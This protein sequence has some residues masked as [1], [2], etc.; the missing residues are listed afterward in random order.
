VILGQHGLINWANDDKECYE[1]TLSLI[2]KAANYIE[3]KYEAKGG[4]AKACGGPKY[5][6]LD[7]VRRR[8]VFAATT[9]PSK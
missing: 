3:A 6:T 7:E 1:L 8:E 2:E 9:A 4:D 5:Q